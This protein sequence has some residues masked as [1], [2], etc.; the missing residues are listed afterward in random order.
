[1]SPGAGDAL[2]LDVIRGCAIR[3]VTRLRGRS[4]PR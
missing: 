3:A 1:M 2:S 4:A